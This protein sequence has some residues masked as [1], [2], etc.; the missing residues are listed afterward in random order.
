MIHKPKRN[1]V[2]RPITC[3]SHFR[4]LLQSCQPRLS[5]LP[6]HVPL[7]PLL[8]SRRPRTPPLNSSSPL[9]RLVH[10]CITF[11]HLRVRARDAQPINKLMG[12]WEAILL[13]GGCHS[14]AKRANVLPGLTSL[15][16]HCIVAVKS[17]R[18]PQRRSSHGYLRP[19]SL[20]CRDGA[21]AAVF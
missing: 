3:G 18:N 21:T 5:L 2:R 15:L 16:V 8:W 7:L 14:E 17:H 13:D 10:C 9:A 1:L 19:P 20:S 4:P 6:C 12:D 11:V